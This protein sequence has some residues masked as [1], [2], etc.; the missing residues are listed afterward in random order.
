[1]PS[2]GIGAADIVLDLTASGVTDVAG[3]SLARP[4]AMRWWLVAGDERIVPGRWGIGRGEVERSDPCTEVRLLGTGTAGGEPR[5]LAGSVHDTRRVG[6]L[7]RRLVLGKAPLLI[8]KGLQRHGI[9]PSTSPPPPSEPSLPAS[10]PVRTG[11][12]AWRAQARALLRHE[13]RRRIDDLRRRTGRRPGMWS[14]YIGHGDILEADLADTVEARPD[15]DD[16]WADPFLWH[17]GGETYVFFEAYGYRTMRGRIAVGKLLA[18]GRLETLGDVMAPAHHLSYPLPLEHEGELLMIPECSALNR[19]E[20][21][22]CSDFPLRFERLA[23]RF[24]GRRIVDL[25]LFRRDAQW[26]MFCGMGVP[27]VADLNSELYAFAVDGPLMNEIVPH[28]RNPIVTDSRFARPAGK[29]FEQGGRWYRPSQ[30]SSHGRYGRGLNLMEI[31]TLSLDVYEEVSVR[32]FA[33][34]FADGLVGVHHLDRCGELFVVDGC[35]AIGGRRLRQ[36]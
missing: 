17:R 28:R 11:P 8:A 27:G 6:A 21:W 23:T 4:G 7:N 29:V 22:R 12:P 25:T 34:D 35:H 31:R 9:A 36:A 1:M 2:E 32:R 19:V 30:D 24:E 15:G 20:I 26:W 14:L 16:Y 10:L 18:D 33:P 3:T 5:L 13:G